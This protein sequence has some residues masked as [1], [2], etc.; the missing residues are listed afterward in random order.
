MSEDV[1]QKAIID[2]TEGMIVVDAGPGTGKTKTVVSRCINLLRKGAGKDDIVM[3][4]FTRNAAEEMRTRL[5]KAVSDL[6]FME[7][8]GGF[9]D[10][11]YR[12]M[13]TA[14][15]G[16]RI[17]TFD[18]FC[19]SVVKSSPGTIGRFFRFDKEE[20]TRSADITENE[21][22][23]RVYFRRFLDR[24]LAEHASEYGDIAALAQKDPKSLYSLLERLMARGIIPLRSNGETEG[25]GRWFGGNDGKDLLGD[26]KA[27]RAEMSQWNPK[28]EDWA[29]VGDVLKVEGFC[30]EDFVHG[31]RKTDEENE[32]MHSHLLDLAAEDESRPALLRM[33]H[34]IYYEF[35]RRSVID[36][37]LTFGLAAT[38][39]FIVLYED[40]EARK[41]IQCRYLIIDEFQDTN[42]NQLM[43]ALM[44]LREPNLCV[45]GDWKQGIYGFR[46]VSIENITCFEERVR[47]LRRYLNDDK[48]RVCYD[49][50]EVASLPLK[51]GYRSSQ[52]IV[53]RAFDAL[54]ARGSEHE[55]IP[56][57]SKVTTISAAWDAP[58]ELTGFETV[59]CKSKDDETDEVVRRIANYVDSG[60]YR[61]RY[62]DPAT[63]EESVR[64]VRYSDIAILCR[65]GSG[66]KNA[67]LR[68][69]KSGIPA[70]FQ[71][72]IEVMS[73]REGKL[74]LAWLRYLN[75]DRDTW[76]I[77]PILADMNYPADEIS[78]MV[79]YDPETG[80]TGIPEE[81]LSLKKELRGKRRRITDVIATL[82]DFYGLDNDR[83]QTIMSVIS[84]AHRSSLMT[85]SDVIGMIESDM[86]EKTAYR[87]EGAPDEDAVT[88]QTMH[89]SKGLEYPIVI[90][91]YVDTNTFPSTR[92]DSE[93]FMFDDVLGV[94][95]MNA[96]IGFNGEKMVKTSWKTYVAKKSR[97]KNYD[98]ERRLMFVAVSRASQYVTMISYKN[99]DNSSGGSSAFFRH[100]AEIAKSVNP[101]SGVIQKHLGQA[102]AIT[103][104][105]V[106]PAIRPRRKNIGVHA[107]MGLGNEGVNFEESDETAGA[108]GKNYGITVHKYAELLARGIDLDPKIYETYPEVEK[109]R[110]IIEELREGHILD[111]EVECSLPIDSFNVTLRGVIDLIAV[112]ED[113]VEIHDWKNDVSDGNR[114]DYRLQLSVYAHVAERV[115][116]R[117]AKC[118]IQWLV[119]GETEEFD[120]LPM[121]EIVEKTG[122]ALMSCRK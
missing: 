50:G 6:R 88:I 80:K 47:S 8:G 92:S 75:D 44:A 1:S 112:G 85:V 2:R 68:C 99:P 97:K 59:V 89:K 15:E 95:A 84:K 25:I 111:A 22:V 70:F 98:E 45:V 49:I 39:A 93:P 103:E 33:I 87:V 74:L 62:R 107:I 12:K 41:R 61:I 65:T 82:F 18:S 28:G 113:A 51:T 116:K 60:R 81:I 54:S 56:D 43:I 77:G 10:E 5:V 115:Y 66:C 91:P 120:P 94:R 108:K 104:K 11:T 3:L 71:G 72:D 106:L 55:P 42:S 30:R 21:S 114:A 26:V 16:M 63:G 13:V 79:K 67:F 78:A 40:A 118:F 83:T 29:A 57:T 9:D 86:N 27:L 35:I 4:T 32:K 121:E 73:T 24:F 53:D 17:Q 122:K 90:I 46:F 36:D 52:L 58:E 31:K 20:L 96:V 69:R 48:E 64:A 19:L 105:P 101:L 100:Y 7:N 109:A 34:D 117:R 37:R 38:F 14:A 102:E 76:G 119:L 23:N 110:G